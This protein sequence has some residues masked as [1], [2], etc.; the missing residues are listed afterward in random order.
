M[1]SPSRPLR[2]QYEQAVTLSRAMVH[3][4]SR[5]TAKCQRVPVVRSS[6]VGSPDML[7]DSYLDRGAS[8]S[9]GRAARD[10]PAVP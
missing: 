2:L 9:K 6:D 1:R 8:K 4:R 3:K 10:G 5:D 7:P